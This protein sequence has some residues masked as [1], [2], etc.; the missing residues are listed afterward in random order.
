MK[1]GEALFF[2]DM[3]LMKWMFKQN[4]RRLKDHKCSSK[5]EEKDG[6]KETIHGLEQLSQQ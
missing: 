5:I 2:S 3:T 4:M 6:Q 1:K